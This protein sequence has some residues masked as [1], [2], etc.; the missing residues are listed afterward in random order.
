MSDTVVYFVHTETAE[1]IPTT[2][3]NACFIFRMSLV[4]HRFNR[5]DLC[6]SASSAQF[7]PWREQDAQ[8]TAAI[9]Y[10][11]LNSP[12][13]VDLVLLEILWQF[14]PEAQSEKGSGLAVLAFCFN[15]AT[16]PVTSAPPQISKV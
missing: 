4:Y 16:S 8:L 7:L 15:N 6:V 14:F 10:L 5:D 13:K 12:L 1:I 11:G 9:R 2:W 3:R